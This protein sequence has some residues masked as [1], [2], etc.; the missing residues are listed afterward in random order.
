M[1]DFTA[2]ITIDQ[3]AEAVFAFLAAPSNL[4]LWLE[5]VEEVDFDDTPARRGARFQMVRSLPG[6]RV[7]NEVEFVDFDPERRVTL[8]SRNG[9]TPFRYEYRLDRTCHSTRITLVGRISAE[10]LPGPVAHLDGVATGLFKRG[11]QRNLLAL[12][13]LITSSVAAN[14]LRCPAS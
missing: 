11:M 2:T 9:P 10:G 3:P 5:A 14:A 12:E 6:R 13:R 8:E 7:V 1:G 4:P